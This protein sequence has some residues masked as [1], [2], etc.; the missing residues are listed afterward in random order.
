MAD[1]EVEIYYPPPAKVEVL[2]AVEAMDPKDE[3]RFLRGL[4]RDLVEQYCTVRVEDR[5]RG[6]DIDS[7]FIRCNATAIRH[8][9]DLGLMKMVNDGFGRCV[10][11]ESIPRS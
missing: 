10:Q 11:A 4:L 2:V 5:G 3:V 7:G 1:N 9:C 8:L 6:Y